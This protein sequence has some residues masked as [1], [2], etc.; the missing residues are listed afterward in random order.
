MHH[1]LGVAHSFLTPYMYHPNNIIILWCTRGM[2]VF[3]ITI[4]KFNL[5]PLE[6]NGC[7][8]MLHLPSNVLNGV[9][10]VMDV[11]QDG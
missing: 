11:I 8:I 3:V 5:S 1:L 4:I 9:A 7:T 2:C 10:M 6:E